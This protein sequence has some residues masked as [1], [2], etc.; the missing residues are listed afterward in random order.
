MAIENI[1]KLNRFPDGLEK[2]SQFVSVFITFAIKFEADPNLVKMSS[3]KNK[4]GK[5][6][7]NYLNGPIVFQRKPSFSENSDDLR[8]E[9]KKEKRVLGE[10]NVK[11]YLGISQATPKAVASATKI[12]TGAATSHVSRQQRGTEKGKIQ[13]PV[14][15]PNSASK[16]AIPSPALKMVMKFPIDLTEKL[17]YSEDGTI[18]K[19]DVGF[20]REEKFLSIGR[21]K[22]TEYFNE[23]GARLE[24][25]KQSE[26]P[27]EDHRLKIVKFGLINDTKTFDPENGPV[28]KK[29]RFDEEKQSNENPTN[30]VNKIQKK[31]AVSQTNAEDLDASTP[32]LIIYGE[33]LTF[34]YFT[35]ISS[36]DFFIIS[37]PDTSSVICDCEGCK[38]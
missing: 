11:R 33:Y 5:S 4:P 28:A 30:T 37:D 38:M 23:D 1:V 3:P 24:Q 14:V 21:I 17:Y 25:P 27:V 7:E 36:S 32:S 9:L 31:N 13:L 8:R 19:R 12:S 22:K 26:D 16:P 2:A 20:Y 34:F 15:V 18:K 6:T 29:M 10:M 35:F